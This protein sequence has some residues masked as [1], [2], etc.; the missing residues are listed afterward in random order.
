[1]S[2]ALKVLTDDEANHFL[3]KGYVRVRGC[4]DPDL[5]RR[6]IDRAYERLGYEKDDPS[7]WEEEIV[8]MY[9]DSRLP[10][11]EVSEKAWGAICDVVGG[12]ARIDPADYKAKGHFG[13][14]S[15]RTWSDSFIVNFRKGADQPWE[16]PSATM[17]RWHQ[18]GAFFRHFLNSR[19]QALLTIVYWSDVP[20]QAGGT[21]IAPDSVKHV[22]R[23]LAD[24]PEGVPPS[25]M[26]FRELIGQCGEFV[27]VTGE[28]GDFVILHP[29]MLHSS[30]SNLSG[31]PRWMTNPPVV[32]KEPMDLNREDPA[33]FSLLEKAT[34]NALGVERYDF[35]QAREAEAYWERVSRTNSTASVG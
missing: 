25:E 27:E 10:V 35:R 8:W 11:R 28:V 24:R 31:R 32:L 15:A 13:Q 19:E 22:A 30:S 1:M 17:G 26:P 16:P 7:T 14:F 18:D 2:Q 29:F 5:A 20:H 12:E 6:W 3:E 9:P 4:V 34:L 21:F 33:A 23:Y